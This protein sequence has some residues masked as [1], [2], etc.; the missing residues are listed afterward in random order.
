MFRRF[1]PTLCPCKW[2]ITQAQFAAAKKAAVHL[3][4]ADDQRIEFLCSKGV[5]STWSPHQMSNKNLKTRFDL[6]VNPPKKP[7][8]DKIYWQDRQNSLHGILGLPMGHREKRAVKDYTTIPEDISFTKFVQTHP[9][10]ADGKGVFVFFRDH[11]SVLKKDVLIQREQIYGTCA[12]HAPVTLQHYLVAMQNGGAAPT[13]D[14]PSWMRKHGSK[15]ILEGVL[16][17]NGAPA[18]VVLQQILEKPS[19][20][21][22]SSFSD[23]PKNLEQY[24][25]ALLPWWGVA[26]DF[27]TGWQHCGPASNATPKQ[28][29]SMLVVGYRRLSDGTIRLLLQ[30]WWRDKQFV[31]VDEEYYNSC[32]NA[33][34]RFVVTPQ[35][36]IPFPDLRSVA[37]SV[38]AVDGAGVC[39]IGMPTWSSVTT[40]GVGK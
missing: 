17:G 24:G 32:V 9:E 4:Y 38:S 12:I 21:F 27:W 19:F 3:G 36:S 11:P 22:G 8:K 25:P 1:M 20:D 16:F 28:G 39:G 10:W 31:E 37:F 18:D 29:H 15:F 6:L 14:I 33:P 23:I 34:A 35:K 40:L 5:P 26:D 13:L 2:N 7:K 30:N